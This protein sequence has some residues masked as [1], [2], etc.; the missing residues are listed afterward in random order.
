M[1]QPQ[2]IYHQEQ[3]GQ[4]RQ[5]QQGQ[6]S[7][8]GF[9]GEVPAGVHSSQQGIHGV[10]S[11][12]QGVHGVQDVQSEH[13]IQYSGAKGNQGLFNSI[14]SGIQSKY[15]FTYQGQSQ[16]HQGLCHAAHRPTVPSGTEAA[17]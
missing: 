9:Q 3:Q 13:G 11:G 2:S 10:Q 16:Q 6:Q 1:S 15:H 4:Y 12:T 8:V 14:Q 17:Q 5:Y 7:T